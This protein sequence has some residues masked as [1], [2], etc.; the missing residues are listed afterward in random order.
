MLDIPE[1]EEIDKSGLLGGCIRLP[2][3]VDGERLAAEVAALPAAL[4]GTTAG[5]IG[6][7][8]RAEAIFL[9]GHAPA[10]GD[11][12]IED[13]PVLELLPYTRHIIEGLIPAQ[14]MRCLLAR[15]PGG[16]GI[17]THVD[18]APYFRK[19]LRIHV[20]V[21]THPDVWMLSAGRAYAMKVGEVWAIDNCIPHGVLNRGTDLSRTHLICDFLPQPAL[22]DLVAAADRD[23]GCAADGI[24]GLTPR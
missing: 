2:L 5:R 17:P 16:A 15:L 10:A 21:E 6:V 1:Q 11:L 4:W 18:R 24:D 9:R 22:L 23:L 7:H 19:T 8:R 3:R 12:P 20:P 14:P 13:Q